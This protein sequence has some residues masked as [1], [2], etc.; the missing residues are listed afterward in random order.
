[1]EGYIILAGL[2]LY[3]YHSGP[4]T[5]GISKHLLIKPGLDIGGRG[6]GWL[7]RSRKIEY[8][9][10]CYSERFLVIT[11]QLQ[12][13]KCSLSSQLFGHTFTLLENLRFPYCSTQFKETFVRF[14]CSS[15]GPCIKNLLLNF[16]K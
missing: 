10:L 6:G 3:H 11:R 4:N 8:E 13:A 15:L 5:G 9:Q 12:A 1:M 16:R 14:A 7:H 2:P